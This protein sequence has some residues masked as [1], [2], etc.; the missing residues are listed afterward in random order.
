MFNGVGVVLF[1]K[2]AFAK[3]KLGSDEG[4]LENFHTLFLHFLL[5]GLLNLLSV[6]DN[7]YDDVLPENIDIAFN[8][9]VLIITLILCRPVLRNT[10]LVMLQ[11]FPLKDEEFI[12]SVL[13]EIS[14]VEGVLNIKEKKFW[15]LHWGYLVCSLKILVRNDVNKEESLNDIQQILKPKF[16]NVCIEFVYDK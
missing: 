10:G 9:F 13:R 11:S 3:P 14:V 8:G 12:S 16:R 4:H 5:D 1:I 15:G 7:L 6:V 2:Y